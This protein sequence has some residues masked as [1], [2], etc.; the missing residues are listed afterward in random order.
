MDGAATP[1]RPARVAIASYEFVGVVRNG[2]IGTACTELARALVDDGH[3]VDMIFTGWGE[4]PSEEG[5]EHWRSHYARPGLRLDRLNLDTVSHCD[6]ALYNAGHS[7]ALY[8]LLRERD[9]EQPYDAIHF[10][11]SLGHGFYSLQAKRQGLAFEQATTVVCPHSPRRWLAEAHGTPFDHPVELGDEFLERRSLELADVVV[12]PSAHMLDWLSSHRVELPERSYVQQYVSHFDSAPPAHP[13]PVVEELVFFGRLEPRKGVLA[14]CDAL[15]QLVDGV[16]C[17][18]RRVTF[19]GKEAMPASELLDRAVRWPWTCSVIS[20][21]DR[22]AALE[23]LRERGRLAV[24]AS[25]MDN[26]PNT[27][28]EA[29]GQGIAFLA[30]R[31]GG[32]AELVHA[33]DY[34]RTTYDPGDPV[35]REIDPGEPARQRPVQSGSVLARRLELALATPPQPARFAVE[36]AANREAH[37]AWHRA[38]TAA[39]GPALTVP[40]EASEPLDVH[41]LHDVLAEQAAAAC[42]HLLLLDPDAEGAAELASTLL[43][44]AAR[45]P[46]AGFVTCFGSFDVETAEAPVRR[47]FL[48]TGGPAASGLLGNC[49]GAGAVLAR[50]DA[51]ERVTALAAA[52]SAPL[53]VSDLLSRAVLAGE[54]VDVVPEALFHLPASAVPGGALTLAQDEF[55]LLRPYR[56]LLG[57]EL[58]DLTALARFGARAQREEAAWRGRAESAEGKAAAVSAQLSELI[59]SRSLRITAPLRHAAGTLRRRPSD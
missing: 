1:A 13:A 29:I 9:R 32:T 58:R 8:E 35:L 50:R 39:P 37:L 21:L 49:A 53:S 31:G 4:D 6:A 27:V 44:V 5:F 24:M 57:P 23:Y 40:V 15:D 18:L 55:E 10:V 51:L 47:V 45:E 26:S 46:R 25:T 56:A 34:D 16:H 42:S 22:D 28:Y 11:E 20:D 3:K 33:D 48:P 43:A 2:G 14:F 59:S 41:D 36:P 12:S 19:L 30:S 52:E 7:L 54:R 38:A 17:D